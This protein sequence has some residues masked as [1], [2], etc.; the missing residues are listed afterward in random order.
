[1]PYLFFLLLY[2]KPHHPWNLIGINRILSLSISAQHGISEA[3]AVLATR[4]L[5][6]TKHLTIPQTNHVISHNFPTNNKQQRQP[7]TH[8]N[9]ITK[10]HH[11]RKKT[12]KN[13][14]FPSHH[15]CQPSPTN[16][17]GRLLLPRY[18]F[19]RN[20]AL[21]AVFAAV[22][23]R[24]VTGPQREEIHTPRRTRSRHNSTHPPWE[25]STWW[26]WMMRYPLARARK[27]CHL[28]R[29]GYSGLTNMG[30]KTIKPKGKN[31]TSKMWWQW[32]HF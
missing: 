27:W 19:F 5:K 2:N 28:R 10:T 31:N 25:G 22:Y 13:V 20:L 7:N 1:M 3:S 14:F 12:K 30:L 23:R 6:K 26:S 29:G 32:K 21:Y 11:P 18:F 9:Y 15:H 16:P 8:K 17:T 24:T 4:H